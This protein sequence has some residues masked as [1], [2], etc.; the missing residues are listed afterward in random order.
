MDIGPAGDDALA[1]ILLDETEAAVAELDHGDAVFFAEA[2][3]NV[4]GDGVGHHQRTGEL[5]ERWPFDGLSVGPEM[6]FAVAEVAEPAA[7]GPGFE[8]HGHGCAVRLF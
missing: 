8:H 5:E 1:V 6:A 4:V 7:A 3:L 2:V